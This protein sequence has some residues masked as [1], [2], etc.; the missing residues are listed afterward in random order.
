MVGVWGLKIGAFRKNRN[1]CFLTPIACHIFLTLTRRSSFSGKHGPDHMYSSEWSF[2]RYYLGCIFDTVGITDKLTKKQSTWGT[3]AGHSSTGL[4]LLWLSSTSSAVRCISLV[5]LV[6]CAYTGWTISSARYAVTQSPGAGK[7]VIFF[8][9][10]Y[11]PMYNIGYNALTYTY[12]VELFP[13]M[14]RFRGITIFQW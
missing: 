2:Y 11:S 9:F 10:L 1:K 5:P 7:V 14:V 3:V 6:F 12:L 13:Y 4:L 8:I